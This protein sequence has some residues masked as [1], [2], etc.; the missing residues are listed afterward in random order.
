MTAAAA[1]DRPNHPQKE[2]TA[3]RTRVSEVVR[4]GHGRAAGM[5]AAVAEATT[6]EASTTATRH[7]LHY[8]P[9][10]QRSATTLDALNLL[11]GLR[12]RY[13]Q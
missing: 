1:T 7:T 13:G 4:L 10:E 8:R 9:L 12:V 5:A 11:G 3:A 6:T 2:K